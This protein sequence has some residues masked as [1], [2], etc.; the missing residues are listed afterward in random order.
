MF[1]HG[2]K[3]LLGFGFLLL[4]CVPLGPLLKS[5]DRVFL[6]QL[7]PIGFGFVRHTQGLKTLGLKF[8]LRL[9]KCGLLNLNRLTVV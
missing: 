2:L 9:L 6:N 3:L 4:P 5:P 7:D 1:L 8:L